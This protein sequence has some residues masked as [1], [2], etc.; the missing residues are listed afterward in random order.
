MQPGLGKILIT[1]GLVLAAFG[2]I[3]L[4]IERSG[5]RGLPGD[6]NVQRPGYSF[7]FPIVTCIVL[8]VILSIIL[9][10]IGRK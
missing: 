3:L 6:I 10:L 7:S 8:S 1:V 2:V 9:N 4:A 5:F